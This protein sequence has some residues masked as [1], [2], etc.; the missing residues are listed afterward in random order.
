MSQKSV[1][2]PS[3]RNH[4]VIHECHC[5]IDAPLMTA[6]TDSNPGR[7]FFGC[8]MYKVQGFKKCSNFVWLD[9]EMNPRAKEVIG[10]L[11]HN[12]NEEKQRVKESMFSQ[13]RRYHEAIPPSTSAPATK[14][15]Q[16]Q[17]VITNSEGTTI[18]SPN[19]ST[20]ISLPTF[21]SP[22]SVPSQLSSIP[23]IPLECSENSKQDEEKYDVS[24]EKEPQ[25]SDLSSSDFVEVQTLPLSVHPTTFMDA[26][27]QD[28]NAWTKTPLSQAHMQP[29]DFQR[30]GR[31][32]SPRDSWI[33]PSIEIDKTLLTPAVVPDPSR[34]HSLS[35][36]TSSIPHGFPLNENLGAKVHFGSKSS[37][38]RPKWKA[39]KPYG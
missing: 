29:L 2:N 14:Q 5:G 9:E 10:N 13:L 31:F 11:L 33:P 20:A 34:D 23:T 1:S 25:D 19:V 35:P 26:C 37:D 12:L 8:G 21:N 18:S 6:W 38:A 7:R 4:S 39:T 30:E 27:A 3:Y 36:S 16:Q 28:S 17:Q 24:R 22:S 15:Q 32:F